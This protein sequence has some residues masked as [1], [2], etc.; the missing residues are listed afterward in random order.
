M[1]LCFGRVM[2]LFSV[3]GWL[4][5]AE[6]SFRGFPAVTIITIFKIR[7][8]MQEKPTCQHYTS[9][10]LDMNAAPVTHCNIER[11]Q[12]VAVVLYINIDK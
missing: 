4:S 11:S 7:S 2:V 5:I 12:L 1:Y 8:L 9:V 6:Y 3:N 10:H